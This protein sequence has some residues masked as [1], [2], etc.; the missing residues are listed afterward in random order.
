MYIHL[1][2]L[3]TVAAEAARRIRPLKH[4]TAGHKWKG[5]VATVKQQ[6]SRPMGLAGICCSC[7]TSTP[8]LDPER[9][10]RGTLL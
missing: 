7:A 1:E 3:N 9:D 10:S 4:S 5:S 8:W 6:P 2:S